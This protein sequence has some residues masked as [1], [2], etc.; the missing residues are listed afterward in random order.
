MNMLGDIFMKLWA[1][2]TTNI[3][4]QIFKIPDYFCSV[5][6]W[7]HMRRQ[8]SIYVFHHPTSPTSNASQR[9]VTT[10]PIHCLP[11]VWQ[12]GPLLQRRWQH[13]RTH[14]HTAPLWLQ[15][16]DKV[17]SITLANRHEFITEVCYTYILSDPLPD[18]S[19]I[20]LLFST[21]VWLRRMLGWHQRR[22]QFVD[23]PRN[24]KQRHR[25]RSGIC[26]AGPWVITRTAL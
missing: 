3:S 24:G 6:Y 4:P 10:P 19:F 13:R 5:Y 26:Q 9:Q 12:R 16:G 23:C 11:Q 2:F 7:V 8:G 18:Q 17:L 21:P 15:S 22:D 1:V 25:T 14:L 20:K